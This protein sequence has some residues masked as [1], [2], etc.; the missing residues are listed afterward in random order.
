MLISTIY[1]A[2]RKLKILLLSP[3]YSPIAKFVFYLNGA[4]LG[5]NLKVR[6]LIKIIVTR[7]GM[8]TIGDNLSINSGNNY[9]IIGRQQTNTFWVDGELI[10]GNNVGISSSV[11]ICKYKIVIDNNVT[12]GGNTVI[13]DTDFHNL[14]PLIRNNKELDTKTAVK[15]PVIIHNNVFI[16][17]HSTIL[18]GVT[19]GEN[20]I[21]GACSLVS[22]S[23]PPNEIWAGNPA[24]FIKKVNE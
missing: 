18:K 2:C 23:I 7:K 22:K 24:K 19:I 15:L 20:S 21:V 9:N 13:Y 6:G 4:T 10:I 3:I 11:I 12:I 1:K 14:N 8:L 17:A 16:G 5:K